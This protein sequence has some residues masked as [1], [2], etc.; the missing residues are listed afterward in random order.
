MIRTNSTRNYPRQVAGYAR[1]NTALAALALLFLLGVALGA[2]ALRSAQGETAELLRRLTDGFLENRRGQG[3]GANFLAAAGSSM[4][5]VGVLFICGFCAIAHPVELSAV[6]FR[7]LGFGVSAASLYAEFGARAAGY[8]ALFV[9]PNMLLSSVAILFCCRESLRLSSRFF[10]AMFQ[11][12]EPDAG[13]YPLRI[14]MGRY[15]AAALLCA[16]SAAIEAVLYFGFA[17]Y[18]VLG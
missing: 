4:L 9:L 13:G 7:G 8:L 16:I 5:F 14:Y 11:G 2:M 10:A 12:G 17:K 1:R 6:F 18:L 15:L 3:I